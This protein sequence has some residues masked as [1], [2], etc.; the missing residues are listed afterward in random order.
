MIALADAEPIVH[1]SGE[2][3]VSSKRTANFLRNR[4][5][6]W[7]SIGGVRTI[8]AEREASVSLLRPD[9]PFSQIMGADPAALPSVGRRCLRYG[10]HGFHEYR[11]KF[12]PQLV[13]SLINIAAVPNNGIIADPMCGSGTTLVEAVLSGR[14]CLGIDLNP[15]SVQLSRTKC[16]ALHLS[17]AK[18]ADVC[19]SVLAAIRKRKKSDELTYFKRLPADDQAYLKAWFGETVLKALDRIVQ[20]I[21]KYQSDPVQGLLRVALSNILR[22]VSWQKDDDLRVRKEVRS[23]DEIDPAAEYSE[24]LNRSAKALV[25]LL[26][27]VD[28]D[29]LGTASIMDGDA[30]KMNQ[31]WKGWE[32]QF[33]AV[34]T[35]PPYATALPYLDTDRLSL[36]YLNL[37]SRPE[38]RRRDIEMIGNREVTDRLRREYWDRFN[39]ESDLLPSSVQRVI[40]KISR[41]NEGQSVGFRRR[42]LPALLAKYFFDMREVIAATLRHLKSGAPAFFVVGN[43]HTVAGGEVVEINTA[44]YLAEI[45]EMVGF[46]M[47]SHISMEMLTSRDIF[48]ANASD[49]EV[50]LEFRAPTRIHT[51]SSSSEQVSCI[52]PRQLDTQSIP[53]G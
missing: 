34:I 30:R 1:G 23:T 22:K 38:H 43:N 8:Q 6:Y 46:K 35:S 7:E 29:D 40:N 25:A 9:R 31:L 13:R 11:G 2:F 47:G 53:A 12:F 18:V 37:L 50:I 17:A 26:A 33:D 27:Q 21:D 4:L 10:P 16:E 48:R 36:C 44:G 42:N 51:A 20:A 49:A 19:E 3:V 24:E 15:L 28:S 5:A 14:R 32:Q 41:Q 45:A 39:Q 52:W